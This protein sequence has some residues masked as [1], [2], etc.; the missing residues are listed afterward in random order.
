MTLEFMK[1]PHTRKESGVD[2]T[3]RTV[4]NSKK[5][6]LDSA[7]DFAHES[8]NKSIYFKAIEAQ[9]SSSV[10]FD[11]NQ[12]GVESSYFNLVLNRKLDKEKLGFHLS[13]FILSMGKSL[14]DFHNRFPQGPPLPDRKVNLPKRTSNSNPTSL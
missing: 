4:L 6:P 12:E 13:N 10:V 11:L 8:P 2:L 7:D 3:D 9:K 1:R 5:S 14:M